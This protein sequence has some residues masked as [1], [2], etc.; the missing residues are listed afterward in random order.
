MGYKQA[1]RFPDIE[2]VTES[3]EGRISLLYS[4]RAL[5]EVSETLAENYDKFSGLLGYLIQ[6]NQTNELRKQIAAKEQGLDQIVEEKRKQV[7]VALAQEAERWQIWEAS[8][9]ER[10]KVEMEKLHLEAGKVLSKFAD[11]YE[12]KMKEIRRFRELIEYEMGQ[13]ERMREFIDPLKQ[14]CGGRREY[15]QCCDLL[16]R[17][18]EQLNQY[19]SQMV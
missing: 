12:V 2:V 10:L 5:H 17:C 4:E 18:T 19:L 15:I 9:K 13:L 16:R 1:I 11:Q 7:D 14:I 6:C 3:T 8:E